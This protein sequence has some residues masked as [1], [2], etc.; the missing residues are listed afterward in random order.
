VQS[1]YAAPLGKVQD[2]WIR[3]RKA[4]G[5]EDRVLVP[6]ETRPTIVLVNHTSF[7][8]TLLAVTLLP[9]GTVHRARTYLA[10]YL[11]KIPLLSTMIRAIGRYPG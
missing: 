6:D 10:S 5:D 8:D 9:C 3:V 1:L 4:D 2:L 7:L 11:L